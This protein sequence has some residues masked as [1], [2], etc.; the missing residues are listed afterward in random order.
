MVSESKS[1]GTLFKF[2][3]S[4]WAKTSKTSEKPSLSSS[5]SELL[6]IPSRSVSN[7]SLELFGKASSKFR[8]PSPSE[9]SEISGGSEGVTGLHE[10]KSSVIV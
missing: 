1:D 6:P 8:T 4:L 9:S 7:H 5:L 10:F 3:G 2:K